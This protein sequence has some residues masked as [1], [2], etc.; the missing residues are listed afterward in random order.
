M[1]SVLTTI[2]YVLLRRDQVDKL[3]KVYCGIF[4][5]GPVCTNSSTQETEAGGFESKDNPLSHTHVHIYTIHI[6]IH[7][8][9][10]T[11]THALIHMYTYTGTHAYTHV[12]EQTHTHTPSC[13][14]RYLGL[15]YNNKK[16]TYRSLSYF[17]TVADKLSVSL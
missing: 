11:Y 2:K 6:F 3:F 14:T 9:T 7:T 10:Y 4:K 5:H 1:A 16:F 8:F 13:F 15:L 17:A 12:C